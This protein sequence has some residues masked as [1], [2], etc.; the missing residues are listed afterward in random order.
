M[1]KIDLKER[2]ALLF[3]H[4]PKTAGTS[5]KIALQNAGFKDNW[6]RM[7]PPER[8]LWGHDPFYVLNENNFIGADVFKFAVVRN[9]F[10][11]IYSLYQYIINTNIQTF[12]DF[13]H[14]L[15][16]IEFGKGKHAFSLRQGQ[17]YYL[18][19]S[20]GNVAMDRIY[21][22][23]NIKQLEKDLNINLPRINIGDYTKQ[24]LLEDYSHKNVDRV[25]NLFKEDF[26]LL[27]YDSNLEV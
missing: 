22:F 10:L 16:T 12:Y 14:F 1:S 4:I 9:P 21:R 2:S 18:L 15:D 25:K 20:H 13:S 3:V 8:Y 5:I 17:R 23:E 11:W 26:D 7:R 19:N 24:S 6:K 27:S